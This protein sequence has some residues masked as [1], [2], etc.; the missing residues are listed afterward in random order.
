GLSVHERNHF[1]DIKTRATAES[2][3]AIVSPRPIGFHTFNDI[4]LDG[5]WPH[6]RKYLDCQSGAL[7]VI[8]NGTNHGHS[9]QAGVRYKQRPHNAIGLAKI[10]KLL[11]AASA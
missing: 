4:C 10:G 7:H 1:A 5:I 3:Y 8:D 11:D 9:S 6:I 2:D